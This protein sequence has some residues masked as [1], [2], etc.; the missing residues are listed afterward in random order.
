MEFSVID[1]KRNGSFS[2]ASIYVTTRRAWDG[3]VICPQSTAH[4]S[5]TSGIDAVNLSICCIRTKDT[6]I[7]DD[8]GVGKERI[9]IGIIIIIC[10]IAMVLN[11]FAFGICV[12]TIKHH[13]FRIIPVGDACIRCMGIG[14]V[15]TITDTIHTTC[16]C[17][18]DT[19]EDIALLVV[20]F[21]KN[22]EGSAIDGDGTVAIEWVVDCYIAVMSTT[23]TTAIKF[24]NNHASI[25]FFYL[26][27]F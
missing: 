18:E 20:A 11:Q 23:H 27:V 1:G 4:I 16:S 13:V 6:I 5:A 3:T 19:A 22:L 10:V 2:L 17:T 21:W 26:I 7:D 8:L 12:R 25:L 24:G 9:Y 15:I 14:I